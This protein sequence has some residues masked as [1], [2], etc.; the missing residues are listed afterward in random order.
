MKQTLLAIAGAAIGGTLGYHAFFW[1]YS[2]GFYGMIIPGGLLGLGASIGK[3][4]SIWLAVVFGLAALALGLFT[5]WKYR[6]FVKDDGLVYFLLHVTDKS[7]VTLLMIAVGA[8]LGFW[9]PFR[10]IDP[11]RHPSGPTF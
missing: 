7:M 10:R 2:Q 4:R 9:V 6:P 1:V 5:E 3:I 11:P 8:A